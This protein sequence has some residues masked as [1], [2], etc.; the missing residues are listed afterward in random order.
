MSWIF[1]LVILGSWNYEVNCILIS[2]LKP[3]Q[4]KKTIQD[5]LKLFL[6]NVQNLR[7]FYLKLN[8]LAILKRKAE[9]YYHDVMFLLVAYGANH[10]EPTYLL[11]EVYIL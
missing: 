9:L 4:M 6:G 10:L 2:Y 1:S 3:F 7:P 8:A 5:I 11:Y